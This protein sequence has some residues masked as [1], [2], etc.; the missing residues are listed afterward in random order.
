MTRKH[1]QYNSLVFIVFGKREDF[2]EH[3]ARGN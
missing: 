1:T 3:I 2:A